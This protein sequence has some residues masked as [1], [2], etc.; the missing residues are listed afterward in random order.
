MKLFKSIPN[1]DF[2]D[3]NFTDKERLAL[4]EKRANSLSRRLT[5][6][7]RGYVILFA[8]VVVTFAINDN[9]NHNTISRLNHEESNTKKVQIA[10]APTGVCLREGIKSGL[11]ILVNFADVLEKAES[12]TPASEKPIV[13]LFINLTRNAEKP[14]DSYVNLQEKRYKGVQCPEPP[15]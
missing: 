5:L 1:T 11:P 15:K 12:T 7:A 13:H 3:S 14:L 8:A 4:L 10:G 2:K 6:M 9:S